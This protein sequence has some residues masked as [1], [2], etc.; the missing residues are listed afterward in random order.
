MLFYVGFVVLTE[1]VMK[2]TIFWGITPY[3]P[4]SVNR[5]F[6]GTYRLHLHGR[7]NKLSRKPA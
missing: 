3:S 2:S 7:K 6:G 1:V 4:L 5:H